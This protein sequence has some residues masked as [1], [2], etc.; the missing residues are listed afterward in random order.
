MKII[1]NITATRHDCHEY[2][3]KY[4]RTNGHLSITATSL[5][6]PGCFVPTVRRSIHFTLVET[7]LQRPPLYNGQIILHKGGRCGEAQL[8]SV[9]TALE[10]LC[11][12][13]VFAVNTN[14][15][16]QQCSL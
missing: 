2:L 6:Q 9:F 3:K 12:V 4:S 11:R 5:Q 13:H 7:S 1:K 10:V 15:N 16:G 8:Y 14:V